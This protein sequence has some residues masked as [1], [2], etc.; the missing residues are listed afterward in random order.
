MMVSLWLLANP[1]LNDIAV[2]HDV[3]LAFNAS[4]AD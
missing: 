3:V 2:L 4:L 1:K